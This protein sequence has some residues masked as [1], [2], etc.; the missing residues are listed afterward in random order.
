M[1][2]SGKIH[3]SGISS[4]TLVP[5][6]TFCIV[7]CSEYGTVRFTTFPSLKIGRLEGHGNYEHNMLSSCHESFWLL[8]SIIF[9]CCELFSFIFMPQNFQK[10]S[11]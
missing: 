10:F 6:V 9:E 2:S 7:F 1:F 8:F 4:H 11:K 3:F 5:T